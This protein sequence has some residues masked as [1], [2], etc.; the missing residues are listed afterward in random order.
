MSSYRS[1]E[2]WRP[3]SRRDGGI[4]F[5][6]VIIFIFY[7]DTDYSICRDKPTLTKVLGKLSRFDTI[8]HTNVFPTETILFRQT[9]IWIK[10]WDISIHWSHFRA[11]FVCTL[12]YRR[13]QSNHIFLRS[14]QAEKLFFE[15]ILWYL[16]NLSSNNCVVVTAALKRVLISR[17]S[18]STL[19]RREQK[20]LPWP[21]SWCLLE[22]S[23]S[24]SAI[25]WSGSRGDP[26]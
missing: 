3:E 18:V 8:F 16:F 17:W 7:P 11:I 21:G 2:L 14:C 22:S 20:P 26:F 15:I 12:A 9:T 24:L 19:G 10:I 1:G 6:I 25:E 5:N 23:P 4:F 13:P